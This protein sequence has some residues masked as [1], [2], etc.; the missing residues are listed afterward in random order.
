M[1]EHILRAGHNLLCKI[2]NIHLSLQNKQLV[3]K[4]E[5]LFLTERKG[6]CVTF[7]VDLMVE[8]IQCSL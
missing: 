3:I 5:L 6:V 7:C 2:T 1:L 4:N 8:K